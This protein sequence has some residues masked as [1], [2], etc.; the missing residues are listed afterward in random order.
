MR[1]QAVNSSIDEVQRLLD[2]GTRLETPC[3]DGAVAWHVWGRG[4]PVLLLH[5][6]GGSWTHWLRNILPLAGAGRRVIVPDLPGFGDSALPPQGNDAD[7][8]AAPIEL[9]LQ[10]LLG[11]E[12][13]D[14]VGF[15]FGALVG[16]FLATM[17]DTRVARLVLVGAPGLGM[18]P[19]DWSRCGPGAP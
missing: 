11:D 14:V 18:S 4:K 17:P 16:G 19:R 3:G 8:L 1:V 15:S 5:G 2:A 10:T 13:C 12:S 6:G 9:G 7:A